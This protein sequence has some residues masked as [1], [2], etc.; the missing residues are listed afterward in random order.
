MNFTFITKFSLPIERR[1]TGRES[2]FLREPYSFGNKFS[3]K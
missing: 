2:D 1:M 3:K